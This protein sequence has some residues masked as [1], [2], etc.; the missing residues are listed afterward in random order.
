MK[1]NY[2]NTGYGPQFMPVDIGHKD[3]TALISPESAFWTLVRKDHLGSIISDG[4]FISAFKKQ[5]AEFLKEMNT[6]RFG[7]KPSAV[8]FNP[9]DRC[10]FN[11]T[12]CYIP[13]KMRRHGDNMSEE[14]LLKGLGILKDYFKKTLPKG[15]RP[16]I[17]FHGAEPLM[18]KEVVFTGIEK[19]SDYFDFG[20]QTNA[21]MLDDE[22][23]AFVKKHKVGIGISIDGPN[24]KTAD[25]LRKDWKGE[26]YFSRISTVIE[27]LRDHPGFNVICTI[28]TENMDRLSDTVDYF[29]KSGVKVCMLNIIRCTQ[30]KSRTVKP[31]DAVAAKHYIKA[32]DR[33]WT[34]YKKTGRKIIVANFANINFGIVAPSGRK[35]M[36]DI[37]PCGVGRCFFAVSAKGDMFPCSEFVGVPEFNGGNLFKDNIDD[38]LKTD[39]F[40]LVSER[41]TEEIHPCK[42]C[43]IQHFCG[44]PCPAEAYTMN[45]RNIKSRGAFCEFYEEQ[46]R[47]A[48]RLIADGKENDFLPDSWS[49]GMKTNFEFLA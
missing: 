6:L 32:L 36:C 29:H 47:Y 18:N 48:F 45:D 4:K 8:Y 2:L 30:K 14:K 41:K 39:V 20:I 43:A 12:Y 24:E 44:S 49:R 17:I 15:R 16:Q 35:L 5:E 34:L 27:K 33:S 26:G 46:V 1:S 10:N 11:C 38:V 13:E 7:L 28:T 42:T 9:T 3:F 37:S 40:R 21:T 19:Y 25:S 22:A 31:G 23:I